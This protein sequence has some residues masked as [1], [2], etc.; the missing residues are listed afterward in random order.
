MSAGSSGQSERWSRQ[1]WLVLVGFVVT[2]LATY[3][4]ALQGGFVWDDDENILQSEPLRNLEGLGRIWTD[5]FATQQFYPVTHST[6]WVQYQFWG[7]WTVPYHVMNVLLHACAAFLLWRLLCKLRHPAALFAAALFAFHPLN[8][9]SVAWITERKNVLSMSLALWSVLMYLR[10][11]DEAPDGDP[12][13]VRRRRR[14]WLWLGAFTLFALALASKTAVSMFAPVLLLLV[15]ARRGGLRRNDVIPLAPFFVVGVLAGLLTAWIERVHVSAQGAPFDWSMQER[16]LIAGRAFWFYLSKLAW[17]SDLVFVYP[18]WNIDAGS[19]SQWLFPVAAAAGLVGFTALRR[20][21]GDW[22]AVAAWS[23]FALIFPALGFFNVAFMRFTYVQDHFAYYAS[24]AALAGAAAALARMSRRQLA[25][26][27]LRFGAMCGLAALLAAL[28]FRQARQ[29][30]SY[31]SLFTHVIRENPEAWMAHYNLAL[32]YQNTGRTDQAIDHYRR[33]LHLRP[34]HAATHTNLA[35]ALIRTGLAT[36]A[37]EHFRQAAVLEPDHAATQGNLAMALDDQGKH[38][39]ARK[40]YA[41]ALALEPQ[42]TKM[43]RRFAWMLATTPDDDLVD[44]KR[45]VQLAMTA[46][47]NT[48]KTLPRCLDTLAAAHAAA[49]QTRQAVKWSSQA[50]AMA[51]Q[52]GNSRAA[53]LYEARLAVYRRG[54][55]VVEQGVNRDDALDER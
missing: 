28:S 13:S 46:C 4:P 16:L 52:S 15:V 2:L 25:V 33:M 45:A 10:F 26:P 6:F 20:R 54:R 12:G 5:V 37:L 43:Q 30:E 44:G 9:E 11:A 38:R 27:A 34:R 23:W 35:V 18:R 41:H 39:E 55:L 19:F 29:Y 48:K 32:H 36:E 31:E 14:A 7:T 53:T 47:R 17:P 21:W 51:R 1:P 49:G 50:I 8:V 42:W 3:W 40:H 24:A 22:P